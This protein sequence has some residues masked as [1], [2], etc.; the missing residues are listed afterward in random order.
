MR[1]LSCGDVR[2]YLELD[3]RRIHCKVCGAVKMERLDWLADHPFY[4]KRFAY[5]VG[6]R[7]RISTIK[8]VAQETHL[9]WKTVKE[10]EQ[11]YM[12]EQL[13]RVGRPA[14]RVIGID[15]V[16]ISKGHTYRIIVSDLVRRRPIWFG[17][18]D[19]SE[20]SMD[21]FFKWL[22]PQKCR[23][24]RLGVMDMWKP[25]RTSTLKYAPQASI[26]FDKF[27]VISHLGEALDSV[28][29]SEYARL[30]G[31]DRRFIKGQKYTLLARR[32]NLTRKGRQSLKLLLKANKRLNTAYVLR[33]S[34]GQ[35]WDYQSER[36]ARRFF[37]N[38]RD[39]LKWQRL[40][41]YEKFAA[42]IDR[43]WDG[44]AAFCQPENKVGLG[45]VEGFNNKIRV[46]QRRAY[47]LRDEEYLRLKILTCMLPP[48]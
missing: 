5:F 46:I 21:E 17:G 31:R 36:W 28:R 19:R 37:E 44:I 14:P 48:I 15:E 43:H 1:D 23:Q 30:A 22:G 4:T 35:L 3:V 18:Q 27:H 42:M 8:D 38:W 10:L 26:L 13:R 34:F 33:E 24:I 7:C 12:R 40:G 41:P 29:K 11:Q 20:A 6:R 25:F 39:A 9:N 2:I 32:E 16:S 47:G 45:F